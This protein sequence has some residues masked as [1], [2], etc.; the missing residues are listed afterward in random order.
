MFIPDIL[1]PVSTYQYTGYFENEVLRK[2]SYLT[3]EWCIRVIEN[4]IRMEAQEQNRFRFWGGNSR[5]GGSL[6]L[7][8]KLAHSDRREG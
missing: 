4:P 6:S 3:K 8:S 2:R 7:L 1:K 5:K